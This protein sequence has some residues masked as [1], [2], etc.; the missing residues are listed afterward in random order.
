[1]TSESAKELER[2][3]YNLRMERETRQRCRDILLQVEEMQRCYGRVAR[4]SLDG[5]VKNV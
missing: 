5:H 4:A 2:K 3:I 1:M